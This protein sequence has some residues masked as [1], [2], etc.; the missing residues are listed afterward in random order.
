[1]DAL[2]VPRLV[3]AVLRCY[4]ARWR[5][6]H[7]AEAAE[8]AALLIRDGTPA[9]AV[10]WSYLTGA[11]RA[12]LTSRPG[13]RLTAVACA[14]LVVA[15]SLGAGAGLLA[16]PARAAGPSQGRGIA[17]CQPGPPAPVPGIATARGRPLLITWEA[18]HARAC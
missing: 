2:P 5:R 6:R 16:A 7:G 15:C 10:A 11:A 8:V 17:P 4:P 12:R 13:P 3:L 1:M 18:G 14:L 9:A